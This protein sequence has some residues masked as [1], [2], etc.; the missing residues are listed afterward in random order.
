[1][2][3]VLKQKQSKANQDGC[4]VILLVAETFKSFGVGGACFNLL[5]SS[6]VPRLGHGEAGQHLHLSYVLEPHNRLQKNLEQG[7][8]TAA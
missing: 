6:W 2:L 3:S 4:S 7:F 8:S 1:M 5:E